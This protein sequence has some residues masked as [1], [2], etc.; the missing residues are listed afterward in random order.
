[1][2]NPFYDIL[3]VEK[4]PGQLRYQPEVDVASMAKLYPHY[5]DI[6]VVDGYEG[7][8]M[9]YQALQIK[10]QKNYSHGLSLLVGYSYHVEKGERF[11]NDIDNYQ[12]RFTWQN[13]HSYRHRLTASGTWDVPLGRGKAFVNSG[14]WLLDAVVGGWRL[15]S[16]VYWRSG[17][18]LGFDGM[19]WD[20]TDPNVSD[21]TPE[22]WFN[23]S[24]FERLPDFTPRANPWDFPGLYGPGVLNVNASLVKEFQITE[25]FRGQLRADAFNVINNMSWGDPSTSVD[26]SNFGKITDQAYLTYGRRVQLG[27]RVEF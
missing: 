6:V 25:K 2:P 8:A 20:G 7:G 1:M 18:M 17:N 4:F 5:G 3:P 16:V 15:S 21:P 24:G 13:G 26:D 27:A 9:N 23:T 22:R 19:V 14:P 10:L 11:Y 12:R